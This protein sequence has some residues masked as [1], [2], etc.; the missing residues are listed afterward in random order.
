MNVQ[1]GSL[2]ELLNGLNKVQALNMC[3]EFPFDVSTWKKN[4]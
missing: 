2:F 3:N 4:S 1:E